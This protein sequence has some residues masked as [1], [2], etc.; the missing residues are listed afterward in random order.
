MSPNSFIIPCFVIFGSNSENRKT[1]FARD[2]QERLG[3]LALLA[4]YAPF[5]IFKLLIPLAD[6][7]TDPVS[8]HHLESITYKKCQQQFSEAVLIPFL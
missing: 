4:L 5:R 8:G 3:I 7:E 6:G 2:L 1:N